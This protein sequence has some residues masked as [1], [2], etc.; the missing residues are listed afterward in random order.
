MKKIPSLYVACVT[1]QDIGKTALCLGLALKLR[2]EGVNIG[3]FKPVG[4]HTS[5][6]G[7][8][9]DEDTLHM[10]KILNIEEPL[11]LITPVL[12]EYQY[13]DQY[14]TVNEAYLL[15][16]VNQAYQRVA[17][18]KDLMI[19][20]ALHEPCLGASLN[21]SATDL[22]K[23]F[24]S[25][26]LLLSTTN[27]DTALDE[28]LFEHLSIS[29]RGNKFSGVIFN[30]VR[31]NF[32][33]RIRNLIV[34]TLEKQRI[35][36]WGIVPESAVLTAPTV[37]EIVDALSGEV[38]CGERNLSNQV[39]RF[40]IGAMTQDSAV[41]YF[42]SA[43]RKAVITGG[44]RPDIAL[45]ALETDT[46]VLILT[47]NFHPDVRVK[48]KAEEMGVPIILVSYDTYKTVELVRAITGKIRVDDSKRIKEA[49]RLVSECVKWDEL[50][51]H[52]KINRAPM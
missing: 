35:P 41:R 10:K 38:L 22:A 14:S 40:L 5:L 49:E 1:S 48:A 12:L 9:L 36:V 26:L 27:R 25:H 28:I 21:L 45:A 47:G 39:E 43:P 4:W 23:A 16:K 46:S 2:E 17:K 11:E 8:A 37:K 3:Y 15:E 33:D 31:S 34:P 51:S 24:E 18:D 52:L 44:D 13:I 30:R 7:E 32:D 6:E 19:I 29:Q 20:E 42:R 50:L